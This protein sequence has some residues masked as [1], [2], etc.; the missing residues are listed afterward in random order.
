[1]HGQLTIL[2]ENT[3]T[4]PGGLVGEHG[5]AAL[6][7]TDQ[8]RFL[9]DTGQ[10]L[11]LLGNARLL[12]KD[13]ACL[14]GVVLS[15]GHADHSGGL[16][17]LLQLAGPLPVYGHPGLFAPRYWVG[18]HERRGNGCPFDVETLHAA[19]GRLEPVAEFRELLPG[20]FLSGEVP[21][22]CPFETGDPSLMLAG[23]EGALIP[24]PFLD[25]LSLALATPRGLLVLVGCAHA[26]L[27]NIL[28]HFMCCTGHRRIFAVL[29]GT[30]LAPADP[31]QFAAT[32]AF[33]RQCGIE[34]L[35]LSHCTGLGRSGELAQIFP[36]RV[37]F[38]NVGF[39]LD[40]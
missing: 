16:L 37:S 18:N 23:P 28:N 8:G 6:L 33:L 9:F 39:Q 27:V 25:D 15:H 7:E 14:D 29:G 22:E 30:H 32:A 20:L 10:G 13:L 36:G 19:G 17:Q 34:R 38:A 5:F 40:F 3:V 35:G 12:G 31:A 1:M 21:R 11:G 2:C 26:G 4:R 24:D